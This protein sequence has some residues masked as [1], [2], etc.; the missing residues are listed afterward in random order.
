MTADEIRNKSKKFREQWEEQNQPSDEYSPLLLIQGVME[1]AAQLAE[2]NQHL[3]KLTTG[4]T[5]GISLFPGDTIPV[6]S[7][8]V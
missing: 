7:T 2:L 4:D 8:S 1:V 6:R 3:R 5:I